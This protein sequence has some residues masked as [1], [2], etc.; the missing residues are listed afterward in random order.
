MTQS[1][2]MKILKDHE[3]NQWISSRGTSTYY[4]IYIK[5]MVIKLPDETNKIGYNKSG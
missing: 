1:L 4:A 5:Y 2:R 3:I